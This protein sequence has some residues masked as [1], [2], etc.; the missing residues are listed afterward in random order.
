MSR[1]R[2]RGKRKGPKRGQG[3]CPPSLYDLVL[4]VIE[5]RPQ[6]KWWLPVPKIDVA[7]L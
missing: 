5:L 6:R 7:K 4:Q 3:R 2:D 1:I